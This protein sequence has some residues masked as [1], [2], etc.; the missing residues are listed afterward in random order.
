ME[1]TANL[2]TALESVYDAMSAGDQAEVNTV[3]QELGYTLADLNNYYNE[4]KNLRTY[5]NDNLTV[6]QEPGW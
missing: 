3:L 6:M 1:A 5:I 2:V 4:L